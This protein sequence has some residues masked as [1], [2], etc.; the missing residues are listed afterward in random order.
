MGLP[1]SSSSN[2]SSA[3]KGSNKEAEEI[4][5]DAELEAVKKM[6]NKLRRPPKNQPSNSCFNS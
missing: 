4:R 1:N 3:E 5:G 2:K 6:R